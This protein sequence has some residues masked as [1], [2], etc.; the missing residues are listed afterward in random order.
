MQHYGVGLREVQEWTIPQALEFGKLAVKSK[1]Q[2]R[3]VQ[4]NDM[5]LAF[6]A[7]Q[8]KE[9]NKSFQKLNIELGKEVN[10]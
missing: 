3:I 6:A 5:A 2:Q 4:L 8:S 1:T 7:T 9:G 10:G